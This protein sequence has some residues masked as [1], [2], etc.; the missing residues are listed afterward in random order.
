MKVSCVAVK[1]TM[2]AKGNDMRE[3]LILFGNFYEQLPTKFI[4]KGT[5]Q[6][7]YKRCYAKPNYPVPAIPNVGFIATL[8][9]DYKAPNEWF[10]SL[11]FDSEGLFIG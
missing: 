7:A 8:W 2:H 3:D 1:P 10:I 5:Y 9:A 11:C 4:D 6:E